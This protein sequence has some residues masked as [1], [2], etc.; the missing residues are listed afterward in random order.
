MYSR[1]LLPKNMLLFPIPLKGIKYIKVDRIKN[2]TCCLIQTEDIPFKDAG[3]VYRF[4]PVKIVFF[5]KDFKF[6][7]STVFKMNSWRTSIEQRGYAV[8]LYWRGP[9]HPHGYPERF[10]YRYSIC[11]G[12]FRALLD[13][14]GKARMIPALALGFVKFFGTY[15]NEE[16]SRGVAKR[17]GYPRWSAKP[18]VK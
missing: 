11:F 16:H 1:T 6:P 5:F 17:L 3:K 4:P 9:P 18:K 10:A 12:N 15:N 14:A 7:A 2:P 13:P 8:E